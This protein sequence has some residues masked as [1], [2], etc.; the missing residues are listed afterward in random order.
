MT[1]KEQVLYRYFDAENR[2]LYIGIS[3]NYQARAATHSK[4]SA[5]ESL[6]VRVELERFAD[7]ESVLA[8]EKRAIQTEQPIHNKIHNI[9]W[10]KPREHYAKLFDRFSFPNDEYHLE[11][12]HRVKIALDWGK[13]ELPKWG[14]ETNIRAWALRSAMREL[15]KNPEAHSSD[16]FVLPCESCERLNNAQFFETENKNFWIDLGSYVKKGKK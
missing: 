8:A 13:G 11:L 15:A 14:Y 6:A 5:W 9:S 16:D 10:H 12:M 3:S 4:N 1:S 7:R 2:L